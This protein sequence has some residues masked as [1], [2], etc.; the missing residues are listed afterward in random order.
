MEQLNNKI[1]DIYNE[2]ITPLPADFGWDE[3]KEGIF[4]KMKEQEDEPAPVFTFSI[5]QRHFMFI[6]ATLVLLF[7]TSIIYFITKKQTKKLTNSIVKSNNENITENEILPL[8]YEE[9]TA[10]LK[11]NKENNS[12]T[13]NNN[14]LN[15]NL[16]VVQQTAQTKKINN[17]IANNKIKTIASVKT[18]IISNIATATSVLSNKPLATK[19]STVAYNKKNSVTLENVKRSNIVQQKLQNRANQTTIIDQIITNNITINKPVHNIVNPLVKLKPSLTSSTK[20]IFT[21]IKKDINVTTIAKPNKPKV[22]HNSIKLDG[23]FTYLYASYK[24]AEKQQYNTETGFL[25]N[26]LSI[27]YSRIFA[28]NFYLSAGV[29]YNKYK[30]KFEL[31]DTITQTYFVENAHTQVVENIVTGKTTNVFEDIEVDAPTLR[32]VRHYNSFEALNLPITIGK[33]FSYKKL[34]YTIGLGSAFSIYNWSEGKTL[35]NN[36]VI[37]YSKSDPKPYHNKIQIASLFETGLAL[38]I[39]KHIKITT[40]FRYKKYLLNWANDELIVK[41]KAFMLGTGLAFTF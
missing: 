40:N 8:I 10:S 3:M 25:S 22:G 27:S 32:K 31:S 15:N 41:P 7:T 20:K 23:G 24:K 12:T 11:N 4:E 18:N 14:L 2:E 34:T 35:R 30:T 38:N 29:A 37:T 9:V 17:Q 13:T 28:N 21:L 16:S 19:H 36:E 1:K 39:N 26:Y 33:Q 5:G 6:I